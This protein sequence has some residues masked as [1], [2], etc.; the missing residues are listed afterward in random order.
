MLL[1]RAP[2]PSRHR[3]RRVAR[4]GTR[5]STCTRSDLIAHNE[6]VP[7]SNV[8]NDHNTSS[9]KTSWGGGR[10]LH[11]FWLPLASI[12]CRPARAGPDV[13]TALMDLRAPVHAAAAIIY[14]APFSCFTRRRQ[15]QRA[16]QMAFA[17]VGSS[18][19]VSMD[20]RYSSRFSAG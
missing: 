18:S 3:P 11:P 2:L 20:S 12:R 1:L 8:G 13:A 14:A 19:D 4:A 5:T 10:E 6:P 7:A 9:F 15:Y 16:H 17:S